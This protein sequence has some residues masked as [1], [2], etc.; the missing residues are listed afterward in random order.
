L[1][2]VDFIEGIERG[3]D[4]PSPF[5][6]RIRLLGEISLMKKISTAIILFFVVS[7]FSGCAAVSKEASRSTNVPRITEISAGLPGEGLWRENLALY[8]MNGD[9]FLDII[10]P[11]PR[12]AKEGQ[13]R[14]FIFLWN[15]S[16][17]KWSEG[18]YSFPEKLYGYGGVAVG[19]INGDGY[20]DIAL[21]QHGGG[22]TL[23]MNNK[24]NGFVEAPLSI[25][26]EFHSR[27]I[28][29]SDIN[30]DGRLDI[31]AVSEAAF[32]KDYSPKG[33]LVGLNKNS[34]EWDIKIIGESAGQFGDSV[35]AGDLR[36]NGNKDIAVAF[37]TGIKEDQKLIWL[38]DGEGNF[39]NYPGDLFGEDLLSLVPMV[40][41][42]G[43]VDGDGK[44][45]AVFGITEIGP[46]SSKEKGRFA[47]LKWTG[48]GFKDIS[49]GLTPDY[50]IALD[51]ADIDGDGRS[52]IVALTISGIHIYKYDGAL[53]REQ[54]HYPMPYDEVQNANDLRAGRNKDGSVFVVFS[55]GRY[56]P[57]DLRKGIKAY[58]LK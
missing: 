6:L 39:K 41:R 16:E 47:V 45:E 52:E 27:G 35:A 55:N 50:I 43:D 25:K 36:G 51:L 37:L 17:K 4:N 26:E 19:D 54:E 29:L 22:M 20:P 31:I 21:A 7:I 49:S 58:M 44:D 1:S 2:F 33:I 57:P 11:P 15:A 38:R 18:K 8:D 28:A 12:K 42:T 10:A 30:G 5:L 46:G 56:D 24:G 48:E 34:G 53:W 23:F 3:M 32:S 13:N 40:V 14:P 9:G